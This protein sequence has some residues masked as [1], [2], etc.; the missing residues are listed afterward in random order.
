MRKLIC[1]VA[2]SLPLTGLN[3]LELDAD[4]SVLNF[5]T[6][7]NDSVA[8]LMS[9]TSVSGNIDENT[10]KA[11]LS[12]DLSS[13]ASGIDIRN[14]R[15]REHLFQIDLFPNAVYTTNLDMAELNSIGMGEQKTMD[16][17]GELSLHGKKAPLKFNV[18]VTKLSNGSFNATTSAPS[19]IN[20]N[21]FGL[22]P[23][24]GKLRSLAGLAGIDLVVPVT[25]SVVFK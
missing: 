10:G 1:A 20:A 18:L 3:A 6:I 4:S 22:A 12:V 16:L 8:E 25:F 11:T 2:L 5:V 23:G 7:K 9:F 14:D 21:S 24:I 17:S 13:V 19:F 15:M